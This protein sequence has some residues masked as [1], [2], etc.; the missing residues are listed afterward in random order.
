MP[1]PKKP[2]SFDPAGIAEMA[3]KMVSTNPAV[4]QAWL[5]IM[6]ES[7]RFMADR[8]Q[9]GF[10][11]Q[12]SLLKCTSPEHFVK[13]QSDFVQRSIRECSEE[14]WRLSRIMTDATGDLGK[15][16]QKQWSRSYDDVP[17]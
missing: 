8:M 7:A 2:E 13:L 6:T 3:S 14:A 15:D 11:T 5:D 9:D 10:A 16:V 4:T 1:K 17:L 12:Q